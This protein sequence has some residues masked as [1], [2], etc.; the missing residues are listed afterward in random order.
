[1]LTTPMPAACSPAPPTW[2]GAGSDAQHSCVPAGQP[3]SRM[4]E[5]RAPSHPCCL[6]QGAEVSCCGSRRSPWLG[7]HLRGSETPAT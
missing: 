6:P 4:Q 5:L 1:M 3:S 2:P 7:L